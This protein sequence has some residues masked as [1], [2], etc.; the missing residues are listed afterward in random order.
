MRREICFIVGNRTSTCVLCVLQA[1]DVKIINHNIAWEISIPLIYSEIH[2]TKGDDNFS[3]VRRTPPNLKEAFMLAIHPTCFLKISCHANYCP[4]WYNYCAS[5]L[6]PM[7]R[8]HNQLKMWSPGKDSFPQGLLQFFQNGPIMIKKLK[9][10]LTVATLERNCSFRLTS[11]LSSLVWSLPTEQAKQILQLPSD[12]FVDAVNDSLWKQYVQDTRV[13]EATQAVAKAIASIIPLS[14][15]PGIQQLQPTIA[16]EEPNSRAAFPLGFGHAT[17]YACQGAVLI[18]DAAHRV[19]P[20]AGQG[21][22][23][24]FGDIQCLTEILAETVQNGGSL[25][26]LQPLLNY[27]RARQKHNLPLMLGVDGLHRLYTSSNPLVAIARS[28]GVTLVDAL[29]PVKVF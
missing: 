19:H 6:V 11:E 10:E 18:G 1:V 8:V 7:E 22:N 28:V 24:G 16:G 17:H 9:N 13:K 15:S 2:C 4:I 25:G 3:Q 23:L 14:V 20:L 26:Q 12:S 27:E 5:R 21:V 29:T